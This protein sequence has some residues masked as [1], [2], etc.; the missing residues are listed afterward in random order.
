[1]IAGQTRHWIDPVAG[2]AKAASLLRNGGRLAVFWNVFNPSADVA[3]AFSAVYRRVAPELPSSRA[4]AGPMNAYSA[5]GARTAHGLR[6]AGAFGE[7]DEWRF[8]WQRTYTRDEW[9]DQLPTTGD[10]SQLP[11][12]KLGEL[13]EG[14]GGAIDA[15]GG[16]FTMDYSAVVVTATRT[17]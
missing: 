16:E 12:A 9:L 4:W 10:A 15:L 2:P 1:M 6:D 17:S 14:V 13:L 3:E 11:P 8:D 7:P 5:L